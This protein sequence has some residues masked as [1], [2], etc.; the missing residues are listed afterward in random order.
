MGLTKRQPSRSMASRF[1]AAVRG[2]KAPTPFAVTSGRHRLEIYTSQ[3]SGDIPLKPPGGRPQAPDVCVV[4]I[5]EI[6]MCA[7]F[8]IRPNLHHLK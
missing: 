8:Q 3:T 5:A 4:S 1:I 6:P 2:P 7:K